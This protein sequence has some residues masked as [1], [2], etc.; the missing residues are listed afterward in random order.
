[1]KTIELFRVEDVA[2]TLGLKV[3]RHAYRVVSQPDFPAPVFL[4]GTI[5]FFD[6]EAVKRFAKNRKLG[7]PGPK[8]GWK[9]RKH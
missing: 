7:K 6:P 4:A 3:G 5:K 1:M 2:R 8:P 9:K